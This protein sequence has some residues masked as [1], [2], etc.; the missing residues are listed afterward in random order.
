MDE[1]KKWIFHNTRLLLEKYRDVV[2]S[3]EVSAARLNSEFRAE[4]G[5]T[6]EEFLDRS[7]EAGLDL[8]EADVTARI[9]S[10]NKSRNMLR[11]IDNAVSLLRE[12][13]KN[14]EKF[15]WILY[16]AYLSP[17]ELKDTEEIIEKLIPY[18]GEISRATYFRKRDEAARELGNLLWG[19][20]TKECNSIIEHYFVDKEIGGENG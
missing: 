1:N 5:S 13:H 11:I 4:F 14:G 12:K 17:Q 18:I 3:L 16:Y 9:H 15:Y 6:L 7:Y 19:Y 10:I 2:W 20:T 8:P